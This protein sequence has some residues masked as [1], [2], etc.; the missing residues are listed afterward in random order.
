MLGDLTRRRTVQHR[1]RGFLPE[2]PRRPR[3]R[4]PEAS[5]QGVPG[6]PEDRQGQDLLFGDARQRHADREST[7]WPRSGALHDEGLFEEFGVSNFS[8]WHVAETSEIAARHGWIRPSVY[9][10]MYNA[11]TRAVEPEL[12]KCLANYGIRFHAFNPLTAALSGRN[13]ADSAV[14]AGSAFRQLN[15]SRQSVS[16]SLYERRL[17]RWPWRKSTDRVKA[18][19]SMRSPGAA[20]ADLSLLTKRRA[21]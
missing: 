15:C 4:E 18:M 2:T 9:Q 7:L 12:F 21:R 3:T 19:V 16:R 17:S 5:L 14:A 8:A 13:F 11:I 1:H 10:G 20:L 6:A